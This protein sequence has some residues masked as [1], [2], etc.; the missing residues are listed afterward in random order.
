MK[1]KVN[2]LNRINEVMIRHNGYIT[3][4]E[5]DEM[6][7]HR[8]YLQMLLKK[9]LIRRVEK[10]VYLDVNVVNDKLYSFY[11]RNDNFVYSH[12]TALYIHDYINVIPGKYDI[13]IVNDYHNPNLA[14]NNIFY[15]SKELY[16]LGRKKVKTKHGNY[17]YCYDL[18]RTMCDLI[19]SN[20]RCDILDIKEIIIKYLNSQEC[21]LDKVYEYAKELKVLPMVEA[22]INELKNNLL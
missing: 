12:Y 11:L 13:T 4:N 5:L 19:R 2:N 9:N 20:R 10:G 8:M 14:G 15:V 16:S 21:K 17:V 22:Y 18:E 6:E 7:I 1:N 3:S